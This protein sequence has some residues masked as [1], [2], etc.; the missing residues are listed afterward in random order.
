MKWWPKRPDRDRAAVEQV[1]G[2]RLPDGWPSWAIPAG[3][4]VRIIQDS[5]WAGPW[6]SVFTGTISNMAAPEPPASTAARPD[7]L[8]YWVDFDQPQQDADGDGPYR[9]A[10]IWDRYI[11]VLQVP[12]HGTGWRHGLV[13]K[14]EFGCDY[15]ADDQ[16]RW[17]GHVTQIGSDETRQM[18]LLR[19]PRCRA[20]YENAPQGEDETRRLTEDEARTLYPNAV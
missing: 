10:Q 15:C 5:S 7:E 17:H 9:K 12:I 4:P 8:A 18:I 1:R 6:A 16:N 14:I 3:T 13:A 11:E 19:C 20:L 2:S